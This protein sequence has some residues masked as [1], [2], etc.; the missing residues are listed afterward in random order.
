[1]V[2]P[3]QGPLA[4][5]KVWTI[6]RPDDRGWTLEN[7]QVVVEWA[8]RWLPTL[9][10][11]KLRARGS[12][13]LFSGPPQNGDASTLLRGTAY[14]VICT[15]GVSVETL[16]YHINRDPLYLLFPIAQ[17]VVEKVVEVTTRAS[18]WRGSRWLAGSTQVRLIGTERRI[19][20]R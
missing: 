15:L 12:F 1:M 6:E 20:P 17:I 9:S 5:S 11:R 14:H 16:V 19:G 13:P 4:I 2:F 8:T 3:T 7:V 10:R 18:V